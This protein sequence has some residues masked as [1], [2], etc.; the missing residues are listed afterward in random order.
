EQVEQQLSDRRAAFLDSQDGLSYLSDRTGG[1]T[2]KNSND[3]FGGLK[4]VVEDQEGYYLIG[5]RPDDSTFDR[6]NGRAKFHHISLKIKRAGKYNVRMRNGFYGVSDE[7]MTTT[8]R[9]PQ[10]QILN[11][12]TSPFAQSGIHLHLTSI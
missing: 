8:A 1:L 2:V 3:I 7:V 5:Y 10:Q 11:A 12:L 6:V 4:R 9:T